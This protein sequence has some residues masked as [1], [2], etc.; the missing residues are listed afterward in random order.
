M[1]IAISIY[2]RYLKMWFLSSAV[3]IKKGATGSS[4]VYKAR[5]AVSAAR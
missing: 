2:L 5:P 3:H 4:S 1:E